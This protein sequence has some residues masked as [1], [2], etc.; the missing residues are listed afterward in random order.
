MLAQGLI[1]DHSFSFYLSSNSSKENGSEIIFGG[2]DK[3][4]YVGM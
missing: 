2:V 3:K 4:H 1:D